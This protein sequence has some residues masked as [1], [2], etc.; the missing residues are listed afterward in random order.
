MKRIFSSRRAHYLVRVSVFLV[1]AALIAGMAGCGGD[2][3]TPSQDLE[4]RDWYDLDAVRDNLEGHHIL[5]NDL[6]STTYGYYQLA[7]PTA[8]GGKGWEPIGLGYWGDGGLEC[9]DVFKGTLDGQGHDIRNMFI[10][11]PDREEVGLFGFVGKEGTIRNVG[12]INATVIGSYGVDELMVLDDDAMRTLDIWTMGDGAAVATL[13]GYSS[14]TISNCNCSGN[15]TGEWGIGGL[16]GYNEGILSNAYACCNVNGAESVG[17]L[18]GVNL[19]IW[20]AGT[21]SNSYYNYDE[22]MINGENVITIGA[23]FAEDFDEW[24]TNDKFLDINAKLSQEDGYYVVNN[25]TD[26]KELLAF[27]QDTTLKFRLKSDLDL[28]TEP[29]FYIPYLTGEFDGN[30][31]KISNL[32]FSFDF[33]SDVG[34]FGC[35]ASGGAVHDVAAE[36]INITAYDDIG[37]LVGEN[38]GAV[39]HSYSA[40]SV[41][42]NDVVGGL[43]GSNYG[44]ISDS[45]SSAKV[46]GDGYVGG[47]V[48]KNNGNA[49]KCYSSGNV[50]SYDNDV[51]GLVGWNDGTVND[52]YSTGSVTGDVGA[53]GLVGWNTDSVSESYATGSVTGDGNVAGL[54]G[55]NHG[56]VIDSYSSGY[57]TSGWHSGGLVGW[58]SGTVSNSFWDTQTSGRATSNGG[59]GKTTAQMKDI[60]TFSGAGWDI[61]AVG[62]PGERNPSYTWNIVDDVT[63]PF[64]SWQAV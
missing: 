45:H 6:D 47:L 7:S 19:G 15:V 62:G 59:V 60:S 39:S 33:I 55:S 20:G 23:L 42:G 22:V 48:G 32:S 1:T 56:I 9:G 38:S 14:G 53:G 24:L 61:T 18:V 29:D 2:G 40:G 4:I 35:L 57:V 34:L 54:V 64:L 13:A 10:N 46:T 21:V 5:M 8:N 58:N 52:C 31:H 41:T 37:G 51:G 26:F 49:S 16:V 30:G 36:N 11:R 43:V 28:G 63:Y 3:H 44:T 27:G 25:V 12:V 50:T 17:G